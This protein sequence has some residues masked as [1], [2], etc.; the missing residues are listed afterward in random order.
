M[1]GR[2]F[3]WAV[4]VGSVVACGVGVALMRKLDADRPRVVLVT[5]DTLRADHLPFYGYPRMTAPFLTDLANRS[6][7]F[8]EAYAHSSHTLPSHASLFTSLL[9]TEHRAR[10]NGQELSPEIPTMAGWFRQHASRTGAFT[11]TKFLLRA[12]PGFEVAESPAEKGVPG[13]R[14]GAEGREVIARALDWLGK[15][16]DESFFLWVHLFDVHEWRRQ[17]PEV[18]RNGRML[19]PAGDELR[20]YLSDAHD[21]PP[22]APLSQIEGYDGSILKTD[23]L[24]RSF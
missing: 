2:A 15:H 13:R 12:T 7:V 18:V 9:P 3:S 24:L 6:V 19:V 8:E 14:R 5:I 22:R 21:R 23:G 11:A 4:A 17:S 10:E 20:R 16:R 1:R